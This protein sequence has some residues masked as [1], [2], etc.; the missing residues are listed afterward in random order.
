MTHKLQPNDGTDKRGNK[1]EP[2]EGSG[3]FKKEDADDNGANGADARPYGIGCAHG[4]G[5]RG[6]VEQIHACGKGYKKSGCP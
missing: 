3:F 5:Q 6:F 2:P 1:E 4:Q